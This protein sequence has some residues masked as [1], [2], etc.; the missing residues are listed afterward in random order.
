MP[1]QTAHPARPRSL[2]D[3]VRADF[4]CPATPALTR[5]Q[6]VEPDPGFS[7]GLQPQHLA[8]LL[9]HD[10]HRNLLLRDA[11][12]VG[13]QLRADLSVLVEEGAC[14]GVVAVALQGEDLRRQCVDRRRLLS[15]SKSG[16]LVLVTKK[17]S[18]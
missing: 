17:G 12:E 13:L 7:G 15:K 5:A 6:Q 9:E 8:P 1:H 4:Y 3:W 10:V 2:H 14:A 11:V 18:G 16:R